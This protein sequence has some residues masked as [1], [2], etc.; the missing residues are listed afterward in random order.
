MENSSTF[1]F[2]VM[3]IVGILLALPW[4]TTPAAA[5]FS[6]AQVSAGFYTG[7]FECDSWQALGRHASSDTTTGILSVWVISGP[8][9]CNTGPTTATCTATVDDCDNWLYG[10]ALPGTCLKAKAQTISLLSDVSTE[11]T[12]CT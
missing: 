8:G 12:F 2:S 5:L 1:R 9:F 7:G 11:T 3:L 10:G 6:S 4:A